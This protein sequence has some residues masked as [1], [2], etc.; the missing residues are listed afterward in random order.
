MD[1]KLNIFKNALLNWIRRKMVS[2]LFSVLRCRS[3][4]LPHCHRSVVLEISLSIGRTAIL[5][6]FSFF[7]PISYQKQTKIRRKWS[8]REQRSTI[9][10]V[11]FWVNPGTPNMKNG[12]LLT[13]IWF[14]K[15]NL[16]TI[17]G[18][19][20]LFNLHFW[21]CYSKIKKMLFSGLLMIKMLYFNSSKFIQNILKCYTIQTS[22]E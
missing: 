14:F 1:K 13:L 7:S 21:V 20:D 11:I 15:L 10:L 4:I 6:C 18:Q 16:K 22:I 2:L 5:L 19:E 12:N 3:R 9:F 17:E 8:S